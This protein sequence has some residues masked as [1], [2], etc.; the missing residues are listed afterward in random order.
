MPARRSRSTALA[1]ALTLALGPAAVACSSDDDAGGGAGG[2]EQAGSPRTSYED[3]GALAAALTEDGLPCQLEYE[4]LEDGDKQLSLC[5]LGAEQATLSIWRDTA[6]LEGFLASP[7]SGPGA[8]AV[9]ANWTVDV[10]STE[11]AAQV[12]EAA[13]G[14][15][16]AAP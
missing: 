8:T 5:T 9:G 16:R 2:T 4:G 15:V 11:L 7:A 13:G 10:T 14:V 1:L 6:Q 12:A 3:V